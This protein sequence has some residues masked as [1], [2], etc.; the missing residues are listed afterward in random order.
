MTRPD[1]MAYLLGELDTASAA[2]FER[3]M[4]G[5][6]A[7]RDQVER[8]RPVVTG[9]EALPANAWNPPAPPP[10]ALP[11]DASPSPSPR[12]WALRPLVAVAAAVALLLVGVAVGALIDDGSPAGP[13]P[14]PAAEIPLE[15]V[16][17]GDP[18]ASGTV[19]IAG[20][21]GEALTLR[22]A[23]LEPVEEG[24]FYEL[25]L[26]GEGG[27][28]VSLGS[29]AVD[30]AGAATLD[31]PLPVDADRFQY[32]DVSLEPGDGDPAHSGASVLRGPATT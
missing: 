5:D 8:L 13:S 25:W 19:E 24:R 15:P 31:L 16:D 21:S 17:P 20:A 11:S 6:P 32:F 12:R 1:A 23:G 26:L 10:L 29:F 22:V 7:L 18:E 3:A 14:S 9:L 2:D 27:E 30:R 4:A 28:L